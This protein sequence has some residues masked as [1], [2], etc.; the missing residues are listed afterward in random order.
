MTTNT[1]ETGE[2][3]VALLQ[4]DENPESAEQW[5][6]NLHQNHLKDLS[7]QIAEYLLLPK[8]LIQW[9]SELLSLHF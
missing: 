9:V 2:A 4:K 1:D 8:I 3:S 5:V 6:S 7:D